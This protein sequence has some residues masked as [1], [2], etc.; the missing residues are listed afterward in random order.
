MLGYHHIFDDG[1]IGKNPDILERPRDAEFSYLMRRQARDIPVPEVYL[2]SRRFGDSREAIEKGCLAGTIGADNAGDGIALYPE[3]YAFD[4][5][6]AA[7]MFAQ[8]FRVKNVQV[9]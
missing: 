4:S 5:L 3:T 7:E 9:I 8:L 6:D 2:T 1:H